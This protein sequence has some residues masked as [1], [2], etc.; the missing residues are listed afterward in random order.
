MPK[1]HSEPS[2]LATETSTSDEHGSGSSLSPIIDFHTHVYPPLLTNAVNTIAAQAKS[3]LA[4]GLSIA[5]VPEAFREKVELA[6]T[7]I[8]SKI[9]TGWAGAREIL[10]EAFMPL[11]RRSHEMQTQARTFPPIVRDLLDELGAVSI[12]PHLI[13][14]SSAADQLHAMDE[15]A[16]DAALTVA[17]PPLISSDFILELAAQDSR[18]IPVVAFDKKQSLEDVDRLFEHYHSAG[19]RILKIYPL[20]DGL[21]ADSA[22]YQHQLQLAEKNKWL[23]ILHTG[24]L[25]VKLFM[26]RTELGDVT[27][28]ESWFTTF[29]QLNFVLAHMGLHASRPV[30]DLAKKHLNTWLTTSWQ[31]AD[32]IAQAVHA[33]GANRVLYSS[34]WPLLGENMRV[35]I[36]RIRELE[37]N[38]MITPPEAQLVLGGNAQKLLETVK[39][40]VRS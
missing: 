27:R 9:G 12:F 11:A 34:D 40:Q 35:G 2:S 22:F 32:V 36:G 33:I 18:R 8:A 30:I 10:K 7:T 20:Y 3:R 25:H 23:V 39:I 4:Q 21:D 38:S 31:P 6:T 1:S 17:F 37:D 29:P 14:E 26:P 28:F 16:I 13:L 15:L 5:N 19:V 24:A